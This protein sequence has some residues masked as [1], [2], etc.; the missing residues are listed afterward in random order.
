MT[1]GTEPIAGDPAADEGSSSPRGGEP[2][3]AIRGDEASTDHWRALLTGSDPAL[4]QLRRWWRHV[5]S[6]PRCKVCAAPFRGPGRLLTSA[7]MHGRSD[8]S[9][10]LC[11]M[12]FGKM[13]HEPGGA[14]VELSVLFADIR[15]STAIAE[16][17]SATSFRDRVQQF[18]GL[19][20]SAIERHDGIVDK[21]LGDG[22]MALFIPVIAGE[23]HAGR[24]IDAGL[25]ILEAVARQWTAGSGIGVGV[26]VH[27]G[28]AFVGTLG[29][30]ARLDFSALG[31]TVNVAARLGSVAAA[32]ELVVG[33]SAWETSGRPAAGATTRLVAISGRSA[34]LEVVVAM[35]GVDP[36][37]ATVA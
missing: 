18:Y 1:D 14:E 3:E 29:T 26:G 35:P 5:P 34:P 6:S 24:A 9:P 4:R 30:A 15:G 7:I 31:D 21:F 36:A 11:R 16:T 25:G 8:V 20:A 37:A 13:M 32:G 28:T 2:V 17:A 27:A 33:R 22:V 12:C 23:A 10:L 19:A